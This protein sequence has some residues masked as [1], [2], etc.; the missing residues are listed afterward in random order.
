MPFLVFSQKALFW[1]G[2][3]NITHFKVNKTSG[4]TISR[5]ARFITIIMVFPGTIWDIFVRIQ[6]RITVL[7]PIPTHFSVFSSQISFSIPAIQWWRQRSCWKTKHVIDTA[8]NCTYTRRKKDRPKIPNGMHSYF[9][10]S[11]LISTWLF[12]LLNPT[13][14]LLILFGYFFF[15]K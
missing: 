10:S 11:N 15:Q 12:S 9:F 3:M 4:D 2:K 5:L 13:L 7:H 6:S 1:V 8:P 14:F